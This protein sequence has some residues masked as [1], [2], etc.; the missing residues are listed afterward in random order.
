[1]LHHGIF[2]R[3]HFWRNLSKSR[4]VKQDVLNN[5]FKIDPRYRKMDA[6]ERARYRKLVKVRLIALSCLYLGFFAW[7]LIMFQL[8]F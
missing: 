6:F 1:M 4:L 7:W 5:L 2:N 8:N 3:S